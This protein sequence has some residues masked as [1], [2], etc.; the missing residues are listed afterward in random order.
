MYC[1]D[2]PRTR[3]THTV[4]T[5][6]VTE[7]LLRIADPCDEAAPAVVPLAPGVT[8]LAVVV[9]TAV[10]DTW[11]ERALEVTLSAPGMICAPEALEEAGVAYVDTATLICA[12]ADLIPWWPRSGWAVQG[13]YAAG[14]TG[15]GDGV[16]PILADDPA[17]ARWVRIPFLVCE[18]D[19]A[20]LLVL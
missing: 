6:L 9:T 19:P 18:D 5:L 11:G 15:I 2:P 16:Y 12:T 20:V 14:P 1:I 8:E 3:T 13:G 17:S 7:P 4:G 10:V